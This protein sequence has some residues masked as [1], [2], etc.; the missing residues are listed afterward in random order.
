MNIL[1]LSEGER[2]M[3]DCN[4][5]VRLLMGGSQPSVGHLK[6]RSR[7]TVQKELFR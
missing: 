3:K 4:E 6:T 2:E 5:K 7:A 1:T